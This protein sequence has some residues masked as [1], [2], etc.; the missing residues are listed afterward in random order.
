MKQADASSRV[1]KLCRPAAQAARGPGARA[2]RGL[3][4]IELLLAV[5]ILS[6][7]AAALI[8]QLGQQVPDQ[9]LAAA[10]VVAADLEYAR[11][12]AVANAS[13]YRITFTPTD[14]RYVLRHS[15]ANT[16]LHVLPKSPFR[17]SDDTPDHQTTDLDDLPLMQPAVELS[18]IVS[19]GSTVAAVTDVEFSPLGGTSRAEPTV[20]WLSCGSGP[21]GR[22]VSIAINPVTG[23]VEIEPLTKTLPVN[24]SAVAA[25]DADEEN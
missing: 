9:L 15:G 6:I 23:I 12:L 14:N 13:T 22:Y 5:A 4:L 25:A 11:S 21:D 8:P 24:V 18:R 2:A 20:V 7:L 10:E 19:Q 16:L 1:S 3:S 17:D